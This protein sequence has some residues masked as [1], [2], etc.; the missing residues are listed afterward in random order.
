[1]V[2]LMAP[3][4]LI[5]MN[6]GTGTGAGEWCTNGPP[7]D[8]WS[9]GPTNVALMELGCVS[10]ESDVRKLEILDPYKLSDAREEYQILI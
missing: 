9:S 4:D 8:G 2:G 5:L 3:R 6:Q 7:P 10:A 1:M